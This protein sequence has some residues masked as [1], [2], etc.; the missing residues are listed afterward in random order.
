M[1]HDWADEYCLTI[2]KHLRVAA[3]P[4][5]QLVV[6]GWLMAYACDEP[7]AH[8]IPGAEFP[9]PPKPLLPNYGCANSTYGTDLM[10]R[11]NSN[12]D[13]RP[14]IIVT[15]QRC[16]HSP[17]AENVPS[18]IFVTCLIRQ[19]GNSLLFTVIRSPSRRPRSERRSL[20]PTRVLVCC[21]ILVYV[22]HPH[23]G[24]W[25]IVYNI[26]RCKLCRSNSL[27]VLPVKN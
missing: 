1:L 2:L 19:V 9:V 12:H 18:P 4:K 17:T 25:Y 13:D 11:A 10:V 23:C 3:G 27:S 24:N 5:T 7:A 6:V 16:W 20:F 21:H 26:A 8:E 14:D 22:T 15:P